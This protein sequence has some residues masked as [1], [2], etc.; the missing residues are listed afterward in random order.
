MRAMILVMDSVGV[1][2]APDAERYGDEGADTLGHIA[3]A[4]A[5]GRADDDRREGPLCL[6][7]LVKLG[8]G[9]ASCLASGRRPPGLDARPHA[10]AQFGCAREQSKGKDTPSGHWEIAGVPVQFEW[11]YFPRR[12]PC[13]PDELTAALCERAGL[14][15]ILGNCHASGTEIIARLGEAHLKTGQ[16][17]CYTSADSVFQIAAHEEAFGLDRLYEVC[18]VA[19]RL[20]DG[21]NIGRVIARPF[22]GTAEHGF[23]RTANRRDYS[24][25]PPDDTILD[26]ATSD[27]RD[28]VSIG[29]IGDIFAHRGTGLNKKGN[30]NDA[31][32]D[33]TLEG[34]GSLRDGGLLF[35]NFVDFDTMY[36]HRRDVAGYANALEAFDRRLVELLAMLRHDDLLIITADHGCDPTWRG[37]DHTREQVP[38]LLATEHAFPEIGRRH[39]FAD[40]GATVARHLR[41]PP[42]SRG[43]PF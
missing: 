12:L 20:C 11:G 13:F 8:L 2:G 15:G 16:P 29:K 25:P 24:V 39:G 32:F 14:P 4:C 27:G 42:L 1:G 35:A 31:L 28:I 30:D 21:F 18:A 10:A 34:W 7:N 41:L 9:E 6:P 5:D 3:E 38:I 26:L 37:T 33:R 22:V 17:I 40:I 36:G 23:S 43:I 19:R